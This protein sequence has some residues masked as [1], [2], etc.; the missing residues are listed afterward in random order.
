M[1][2]Q[3]PP[4]DLT[5]DR[6]AILETDGHLLVLG[7][8]GSG[9]TTIA[10]LKADHCVRD[11]Q[12][13]PG[14]RVLFLS[15]A[16]ATVAR[17]EQQAASMLA[18]TTRRHL[19]V[20]TYHGFAWH[21]LR[22]H[23]YLLYGKRKVRL[24]PPPEA[25]ARLCEVPPA[26][27][28]AEQRRLLAEEGLLHFD[29][30]SN[31]AAELLTRAEALR[32]IL[33]RAYP[34][35]VLDEFQDTNEDEWRLIQALGERSTLI[36]LADAD[37]RI[38]EFRGADPRRIGEYVNRYSPAVYDF[39]AENH[40]SDGRDITR[41][42]NDLLTGRNRQKDYDDV[43][44]VPELHHEVALDA[45]AP[46]LAANV[47]AKTLEGERDGND[48]VNSLLDQLCEY[49]RGRRG[50]DGPTKADLGLVTSLTSYLST[51]KL[52]GKARR[53]IVNEVVYICDARKQLVFSGDVEQDWLAVRRLFAGSSEQHVRDVAEH[54][55]HL[56][57]L[58]RGTA[59]RFALGDLWRRGSYVGASAAVR[60]ALLQ[61]H[62]ANA[63]REWRGVHVMTI[64]KSKGK[65]FDEVVLF[66][67]LYQGRFVRN[68]AS[69]KEEA[70]AR[71]ALR[72]GVTR[73]RRRATIVTP[74][75]QSVLSSDRYAARMSRPFLVS[76]P[77]GPA[78]SLGAVSGRTTV[79]WRRRWRVPGGVVCRGRYR[80]RLRRRR[81]CW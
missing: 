70:Q 78:V 64:H 11:E 48:F 18:P 38:Y 6:R 2:D 12:L 80:Y 76:R 23:G 75:G 20:S 58:R 28:P 14:E 26:D 3:L 35:I 17:V 10:L 9:K 15:F 67:G 32:D 7:G 40:R 8:P 71:L 41:F 44:L 69:E 51:G 13:R 36:A 39:A 45:E 22:S 55:R 49:M 68:G 33:C 37:Q 65:E 81:L 42:G 59:L 60:D 56:R 54:A 53:R 25:A 79:G 47:I 1:T 5:G 66:E 63:T 29:L 4:F 46:A 57:F 52:I 34:L 21:Q 50:N 43:V 30:F 74:T 61:E 62:F 77:V 27:R 31:M 19:E 24:L 73:A 16:R 72:V